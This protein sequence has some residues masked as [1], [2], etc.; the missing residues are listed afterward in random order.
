MNPI[1]INAVAF[2]AD[3]MWIAHC[4]EYNFVSCAETLE[5]LPDELL[6]QIIHQ[7]EADSAAG[8]DPFFGYKPAPQKYWDMFAAAKAVSKPIK[9]RKSISQRWREIRDHARVETQV[10]PIAAAA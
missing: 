3:G 8:R 7:I 9:P 5:K 10:I 6:R 4:L 1:T 2:Q